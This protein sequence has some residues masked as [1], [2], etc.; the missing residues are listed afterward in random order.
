M[1]DL[2]S[3]LPS[4]RFIEDIYRPSVAKY[5][6][7]GRFNSTEELDHGKA[8]L[9]SGSKCEQYLALYG[10][11]H[12]H[13]LQKAF[14]STNFPYIDGK[15]IEVV[16]WGSGQ[17]I[18][19]CVLLDYLAEKNINPQVLSITLIEPSLP[20]L[21]RAYD[22][23]RKA[24]LTDIYKDTLVYTVSKMLDDVKSDDLISDTEAIKVHLFSNI[25]DVDTFDLE[26][27]RNLIV[28]SFQGTNRIISV[29]PKNHGCRRLSRFYELFSES[30]PVRPS[31]VGNEDDIYGEVFYFKT[32]SYKKMA[33]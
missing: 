2:G 19:T 20:A 23:T 25:L 29:S 17:A 3:C 9:D 11:H 28:D 1:D 31:V 7:Y 8:I 27:L 13:K 6:M 12:F 26:R 15:K 14:E 18:A 32:K 24:L 21:K 22:F 30:Y 33:Q 10:G 4:T 5:K 16:D